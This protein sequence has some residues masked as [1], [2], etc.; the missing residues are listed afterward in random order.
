MITYAAAHDSVGFCGLALASR[1][2]DGPV[3]RQRVDLPGGTCVDGGL[4]SLDANTIARGVPGSGYEW[5]FGRAG[6]TGP[7][8]VTAIAPVAAPGLREYRGHETERMPQRFYAGDG[9]PLLSVGSP[10][11]RRVYVQRYD[12]VS[13]RWLRR[14]EIY[15]HR[16]GG[17]SWGDDGALGRFP[18]VA[19]DLTCFP[20]RRADGYPPWDVEDTPL[21]TGHRL[22]VTTDATT[23][24]TLRLG[25]RPL[26]ISADRKY[27]A[28]PSHR[29]TTVISRSH[30]LVRVPLTVDGPCDVVVPGGP[31][32][33]ALLTSRTRNG[34]WPNALYVAT[35]NGSERDPQVRFP[36]MPPGR[37]G[38][39]S[40]DR[41]GAPP[42]SGFRGARGW[43]R[44]VAVHTAGRWHVQGT[45]RTTPQPRD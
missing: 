18:I 34:G 15:D 44:L 38:D 32:V 7:W 1:T 27:L 11:R 39:T 29:G 26:G 10:D 43:A 36:P 9:L 28:V 20:K 4:T 13:R 17:C 5:T 16:F 40:T 21:R 3:V 14:V 24:D 35:A 42:F 19:V 8:A 12:A 33:A 2:H 41:W 6:P 25:G 37:C 30:G 31:D 23:W 45:S 22:L